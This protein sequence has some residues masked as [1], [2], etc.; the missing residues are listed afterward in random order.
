MAGKKSGEQASLTV[1]DKQDTVI[2]NVEQNQALVKLE[3]AMEKYG[4]AAEIDLKPAARAVHVAK[5]IKDLEAS[6]TREIMDEIMPLMNTSLG[7]LTDKDPSKGDEPYPMA[8]VRK[9]MV[10]AIIFGV[11]PTNNEFNIIAGNFY[12]AKNGFRRKV[13]EIPGLTD[14]KINIK[15]PTM[16]NGGALVD[17]SATWKLN[18]KA[19]SIGIDET[20]K[21]TIP[22]RVNRMQG[23]DAIIGKAERKLL[24]RIYG[25]ATGSE[26]TIPDGEIDDLDLRET[27]SRIIEENGSVEEVGNQ[28]KGPDTFHRDASATEDESK[29]DD[30]PE[31]KAAKCES[32][33]RIEGAVK[34]HP[35]LVIAALKECD[36]KNIDE[37]CPTNEEACNAVYLRYLD[38]YEATRE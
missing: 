2:A 28:P 12:C 26:V 13:R 36:M 20:D 34:K 35:K 16:K 22:V 27:Q 30:L 33:D 11:L 29:P 25:R 15:V 7:F 3:S 37:L 6:L 10:E 38:L 31:V 8:V 24:A 19:M 5:A 14:L 1:Q 23:T 17:C 9:V 21:C 18:G 4:N 32:Y